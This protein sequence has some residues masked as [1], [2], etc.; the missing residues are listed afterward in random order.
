MSSSR[1][2]ILRWTGKGSFDDLRSSVSYVLGVE[3]AKTHV[4]RL[5]RSV[6]LA[7][8]E[9]LR[10]AGLFENMPG[11]SWVAVGLKVRS[12]QELSRASGELARRYLRKGDRF[13]VEAEGTTEVSASDISGIVTSSVLEK[14]RGTRVS[15]ESPR[16]RFRA[17]FDE[18]DGAVGVEVRRG[19]GGSPTGREQVTCL[20]SGGIHSSVVAW[21]AVLHGFKVLLLHAKYSEESLRAVARLCS[22]LSYRADPRGLSLEVLE[23]G[24]VRRLLSGRVA[25]SKGKVFA[26][27]TPGAR[28]R[29]LRTV[30]SP[31][32]LMSDEKFASEFEALG[33]KGFEG[34]EDWDRENDGERLARRFAGKRADINGVLDGM[35]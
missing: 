12:L 4:S 21:D 32:Y 28:G 13:Y 27:Y 30:L 1:T 16:V 33:I 23:G 18:G 3:G 29:Q 22:E 8:P 15:L 31:L 34:A 25:S 2:T 19:P 5:G 9:P 6:T 20:V 17:A 11:V 14:A 26:G 24:S 10:I 7:G 35:A